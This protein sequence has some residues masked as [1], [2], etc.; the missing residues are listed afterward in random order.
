MNR[1]GTVV[2]ALVFA[3]AASA[4]ARKQVETEHYVVVFEPGQ[5]YWAHKVIEAAEEVWDNLV[6]AYELQDEY[7][8]VYI[9]IEDEGDYANGYTLPSRNRVTV[10][11]TALD[12]GIRSSDNWVRNVVTHELAHVFS[13]KAANKDGFLKNWSIGRASAYQNPNITAAFHYQDLLAPEWWIEGTAQY[14]AYKNGNDLWDTHRDMFLR[15]AVLEDDL[16]D[17]AEI[18]TFESRNGFYP[19]MTYNQGF[20]MMLYIDSAFGESAAREIAK[21]KSF[22]HFSHSL[23]RAIGLNQHQLYQQWKKWVKARYTP[24][25]GALR[26]GRKLYDGGFWDDC[27]AYAPDGKRVALVSNRGYDVLYPHLYV[28]NTESGRLER[29]R[30]YGTTG[31]PRANV[32]PGYTYGPGKMPVSRRLQFP[33]FDAV[34]P[35]AGVPDGPDHGLSPAV[36]SRVGWLPDG[37]GVCYTRTT[38]HTTFRD[39]YVYSFRDDRERRITWEARAGDP[40]VSPDG[41]TIAYVQ[42][43]GGTNNLALARVDGGRPRRLTNFNNDCQL[44]SP[45]WSPDGKKIYVGILQGRNRDIAVVNAGAVPFDRLMAIT[46][47][48][49]FPDTVSYQD[50]LG[51][52]LVVHTA[53]DERDPCLSPDGKFLYYSSDRTGIFNIYRTDLETWRVEQVTNVLGGAFAPSVSPDGSKLVYTGFH[54]ADFSIY[55][56]EVGTPERVRLTYLQRDYRPRFDTKKLLFAGEPG[57]GQYRLGDYKP[58][59]TLWWFEPYLSW[60]PTYITD[61]IGISQM[62]LGAS[63]VA[64]ELRGNLNLGGSVFVSKDFDNHSGPSWGADLV[65]ALK[66][67]ELFGENR[68]FK[69]EAYVFGS[70]EVVRNDVQFK[71]SFG[72]GSYAGT[73]PNDYSIL[74]HGAAGERDTLIGVYMDAVDG[75]YREERVFTQYGVSAGLAFNRYNYAGVFY[76]GLD[77]HINGGLYDYRLGWLGRVMLCDRST[78]TNVVD[79]TDVRLSDPGQRAAVDG[80][81]QWVDTTV[82]GATDAVDMLEYYDRYSIYR[83]QRVGGYYEFLNVGPSFGAPS[84]VDYLSLGAQFVRSGFSIDYFYGGD[85]TLLEREIGNDLIVTFGPDGEQVAQVTA[86]EEQLDLFSLE[87][88]AMERV[89]LPG[90]RTMQRLPRPWGMRHFLTGSLFLGSLNRRLPEDA[91]T[92]P[93]EYRIAQFMKGYP[94]SFD[95]VQ[96]GERQGSFPVDHVQ[97]VPGGDWGLIDTGSIQYT[98]LTDTV[99]ADILRGNGIAW[100]SLEYTL[101]LLRGASIPGPGMLI[102]GLYVTPFFETASVWNLDWRDFDPELLAPLTGSLHWRRSFLRD[103]GI[104][105]ELA[106]LFAHTWHGALA[107][108][109]ARRLDLDRDILAYERD[110]NREKR[111]FLDKDRFSLTLHVW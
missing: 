71:P 42:N 20:S 11:T 7:K 24:V 38:E 4:F 77:D 8:K 36:F 55:E 101:E 39:V 48:T 68:D 70:R 21:R 13:I 97:R 53:A 100:Y 83:D 94:Y 54:A 6:T 5:E 82:N 18:A 109:W 64:G 93:V 16:L 43:D 105:A 52:L 9:Y 69:P 28:L 98:Y 111:T 62:R 58:R 107:F 87:L 78:F 2:A 10:G 74:A 30:R 66:A 27:P 79:L 73:P 60:Q 61:S 35:D 23:R 96:P 50:D 49:F 102:E 84:R 46:D 56:M 33:S 91:A 67:P 110:G 40:A 12:I 44:Y 80:L 26:E 29:I 103:W 106:F 47:T 15:M 85:D 1:I 72:S 45:C 75:E 108:T 89:P 86:V 34:A 25:A 3:L 19:E 99:S 90:I 76:A 31:L 59:L 17:E 37:S 95:P 104:R 32:G 51:L 88:A 63:M 65:A 22:F 92:Y 41:K 14:E 81:K 57:N